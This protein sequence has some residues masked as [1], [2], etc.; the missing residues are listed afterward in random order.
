[1][2]TQQKLKWKKTNWFLALLLGGGISTFSAY[3]QSRSSLYKSEEVPQKPSVDEAFL[4]QAGKTDVAKIMSLVKKEL[5][6][7]II[8]LDIPGPVSKSGIL[9]GGFGYIGLEGIHVEFVLSDVDLV[10]QQNKMALVSK[11]N[12]LN[13]RIERVYFNS[14]HTRY[15]SD[16]AVYSPE[17]PIPFSADLVPVVENKKYVSFTTSNVRTSLNPSNFHVSKPKSCNVLLGMNWLMRRAIPVIANEFMLG[18]IQ[19]S[20][21]SEMLK[22][23]NQIGSAMKQ[24][25]ELSLQ[26]PLN[27]G[28]VKPFNL[29]LNAYPNSFLIDPEFMRFTLGMSTAVEGLRINALPPIKKLDDPIFRNHLKT[30]YKKDQSFLGVSY[31]FVN[32]FLNEARKSDLF[33]MNISSEDPIYQNLDLT[34]EKL[35][36]FIPDAKTRFK[37]DEPVELEIRTMSSLSLEKNQDINDVDL[38][39]LLKVKELRTVVKVSGLPYYE[40]LVD[41]DL[42]VYLN[43]EEDLELLGMGVKKLKNIRANG[44]FLTVLKPEPETKGFDEDAFK[45]VMIDLQYDL[46]DLDR[47]LVSFKVPSPALGEK[48]QLKLSNVTTYENAIILETNF[49]VK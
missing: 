44:K 45:K 39:L 31:D 19:K 28:F 7:K 15:C 41:F 6:K 23:S 32:L 24:D 33:R 13:T 48:L 27:L 37:H 29:T 1:M 11:V 17:N 46:F 38:P 49:E 5:A 42:P 10:L 18:F 26:M 20:V 34:A 22:L 40:F 14:A 16:L 43:F 3:S 9:P 2:K 12:R 25:F 35:F 21:E 4:I 8:H 47:N 30:L 36:S